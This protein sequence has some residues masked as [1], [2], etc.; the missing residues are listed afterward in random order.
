[1]VHNV[2]FKDV[3]VCVCTR[4]CVRVSQVLKQLPAKE[5]KLEFCTMSEKQQ[6][7]YQNM[8]GK[9]KKSAIG[10]SMYCTEL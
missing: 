5:E 9:L 8:V 2:I 3:C 10:E 7:L 4:L 6:L 1:M